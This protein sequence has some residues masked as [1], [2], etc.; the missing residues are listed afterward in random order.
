MLVFE[1]VRVLL[2]KF[3][4]FLDLVVCIV[5]GLLVRISQ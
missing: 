2:T 4:K 3:S 5:L 1:V